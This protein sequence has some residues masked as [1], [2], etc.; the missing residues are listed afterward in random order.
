MT[1]TFYS[2]SGQAVNLASVKQGDR[3][4]VLVSGHSSRGQTTSMA[5]DDPLPSYVDDA[6]PAAVLRSV[7]ELMARATDLFEVRDA[8]Q[9]TRRRADR[10]LFPRFGRPALPA[11]ADVVVAEAARR[12]ARVLGMPEVDAARLVSDPAIA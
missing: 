7:G 12:V 11:L 5:I 9:G 4:I 2:L 1:K 8:V 10:D 3:V 6:P